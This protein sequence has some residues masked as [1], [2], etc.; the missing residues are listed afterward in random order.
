MHKRKAVTAVYSYKML[1]L[2][3]VVN[4]QSWSYAVSLESEVILVEFASGKKGLR[5]HANF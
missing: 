3:G 2:T 4:M 5:R 1:H